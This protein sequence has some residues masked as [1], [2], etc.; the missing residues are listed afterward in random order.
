MI[1]LHIIER[2]AAEARWHE[3]LL[4]RC[5][6][7]PPLRG[8]HR[9]P[10][11]ISPRGGL[12]DHQR[13]T[14]RATAA[15]APAG[16]GWRAVSIALVGAFMALLDTTI[17]NVALPSIRAGLHAPASSLEWIVAGYALAYGLAL[18]RRAGRRR[19][20]PQA[21]LPHRPDPVHPGQ[22]GLRRPAPGPD[23]RRPPRAG[24][25]GGHLLP[26]DRAIIQRRSPG[27]AAG[28]GSRRDH[29]HVH[30]GRPLLGGLIMRRPGARD[31]WRWVF[32]VN[33]FIGA[34]AVPMA[35]GRCPARA[36]N[37]RRFDPRATPARR[38]AAA[39]AD[40]A[41][42]GA[43]A[44]GAPGAGPASAACAVAV[45]L[46]AAWEARGPARRGPAAQAG[47]ARAARSAG[48]IFA[49]VV[50]RRLRQRV[51][52]PVDPVAGRTPP[53]RAPSRGRSSRRSRWAAASSVARSD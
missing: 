34:V 5:R 43:A 13:R 42:R 44:A 31:G 26:G 32:L 1:M 14:D 18:C 21:A 50:L 46:L 48:A 22:R 38:G 35:T 9:R 6:R 45:A 7:S 16:P 12:N 49:A 2:A 30:R 29:R 25:G 11:A 10:P 51:L 33:L 39:A 40:P 4:G 52:H 53:E 27:G 23:R 37:R 17:V 28:F 24:A 15:T 36:R 8:R 20:R 19:V 41:G 3:E 47:P